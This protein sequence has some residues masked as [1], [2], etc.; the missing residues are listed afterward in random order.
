MRI[1]IGSICDKVGPRYT[2]A[3]LLL[4]VASFVFGICLVEVGSD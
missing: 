4:C 2:F 1:A 3:A